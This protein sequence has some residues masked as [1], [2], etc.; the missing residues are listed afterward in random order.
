METLNKVEG[1]FLDFKTIKTDKGIEWEMV[2]RKNNTKAV[3]IIAELVPSNKYV[4]ITEYRPTVDAKVIA[5]PAGLVDNGESIKEAAIREFKEETGYTIT[6]VI[7]AM[8]PSLTSVGLTDEEV[9]MIY[10]E[11]DE[12]D[13]V[14]KNPKQCLEETEDITIHLIKENEIHDFFKTKMGE[15]CKLTSRLAAF[16]LG[17][18]I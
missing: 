9:A 8:P 13:P 10:C 6:K 14:N 5:F 1:K 4:L 17:K 3:M 11:V 12:K 7:D 16:F 15:G 18:F 2:S